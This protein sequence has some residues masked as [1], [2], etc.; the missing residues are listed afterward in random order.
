[1][2]YNYIEGIGMIEFSEIEWRKDRVVHIAKK[3]GITPIEVEE[4]CFEEPLVLKGPGKKN[5]HLY[6]V[7]GQTS[8]G[9][10]LFVVLKPLGRGTALPVTAREMSTAQRQRYLRHKRG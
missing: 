5:R 3:H 2:Y 7:L 1:M 10:Y 9:R 6:Y 8:A 4:V